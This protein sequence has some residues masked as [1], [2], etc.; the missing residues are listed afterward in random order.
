MLVSGYV[1]GA[2]PRR[3]PRAQARVGR[4]RRGAASPSSRPAANAVFAS[5]D[6]T[7]TSTRS[8]RDAGSRSS[9]S[10]REGAIAVA[11]RPRGAVRARARARRTRPGSGDVF[12]ATLLVA[13][14]RG[15]DLADA[16]ARGDA[17]RSRL[18]RVNL[19]SSLLYAAERNPDA[20]AVVEGETR[21]TYAELLDR[22]ARLAGGPGARA[23][24]GDR[25]AAVVRCR[26]ETVHALLGVP[27]AR[28]DVR[29][30]LAARVGGRPRRT[31]ARTRARRSSSRPTS[32]SPPA[33]DPHPGALD[34]DDARR[35]PDALHLRA[36]PAGRR[37]SRA[38]T[39]P[40][41]R[42]ASRRSSTR[43][44]ATATGRSAAC[45][46]TTRWA[47]TR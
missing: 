16:L 32:S 23:R 35:E 31:A 2:R 22:A 46:S 17:G 18:A 25:L 8:R 9:R 40:T 10:A 27:V 12:A 34:A 36:R 13:L 26:L 38:R 45:R 19:A 41:A 33:G 11:G 42:A 15:D 3:S 21:L 44:T 5:G 39:A 4:A 6:A 7:A 28:R 24:A 29:P 43:A 1:R 14:A 30:A 37:A 47:S 20:E